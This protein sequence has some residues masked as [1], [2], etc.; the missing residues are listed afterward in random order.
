MVNH[1][2][3]L[4]KLRLNH[5]Q[6]NGSKKRRFLVFTDK[7][8]SND[9]SWNEWV[10]LPLRYC[11]LPRYAMLTLS[12]HELI[13][14]TE[15]RTVGSTTIS[16]FASDGYRIFQNEKKSSEMRFFLEHFDKEFTI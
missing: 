2:V 7:K 16:L 4:F 1:F 9:F 3:C 6:I 8:Q 14:P 12:I 13:S 10:T 15:V 5:L 11:D